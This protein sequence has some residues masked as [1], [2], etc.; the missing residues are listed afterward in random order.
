MDCRA[1]PYMTRL[2]TCYPQSYTQNYPQ[3]LCIVYLKRTLE[4]RNYK[5]SRALG[6]LSIYY[7]NIDLKKIA[8]ERGLSR[9]EPLQR[10]FKKTIDTIKQYPLNQTIQY[11]DEDNNLR[12]RTYWMLSYIDENPKQGIIQLVIDKN[13]QEYYVNELLR[14]PEIQMDIKFHENCTSSYTYPF[15]IGRSR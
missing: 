7:M 6:T 11:L 9:W 13:F 10:S 8:S 12:E 15:V 2:Y 14:H 1:N 4:F 5:G 3:P